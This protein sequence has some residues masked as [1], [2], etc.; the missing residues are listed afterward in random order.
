[1][2][3]YLKL[4]AACF[5][6][7]TAD[8]V[9]AQFKLKG[10]CIDKETKQ[11]VPFATVHVTQRSIW[12]DADQNGYF[13]IDV[14]PQDS[15]Y[16]SSVGYLPLTRTSASFQVP[17]T[18]FLQSVVISLPEI[19]IGQRKVASLG[20]LKAKKTFDMNSKTSSR[21]EMATRVNIPSG[22]KRFQLQKIN[23]AGFDF[24]ASNP[25]RIHV[26]SVGA[27]GQPDRELLT[28]DIVITSNQ[29]PKGV[30]AIDVSEQSIFLSANFFVA[31]QWI[32]DK[33][34]QNRINPSKRTIIGP[35]ILCTY[36]IK[37]TVTYQRDMSS[38]MGYKWALITDGVF[39]PYDYKIPEKLPGS[40]LNMLISCDILY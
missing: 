18:F 9:A 30:V 38:G 13:E 36:T 11:V 23:I 7:L 31:V 34:N 33:N 4:I 19:L 24:N 2:T 29:S 15:I 8:F 37:N 5:F 10:V 28:K 26:Y 16:I 21:F 1:M 3:K 25:V 6:L 32:S 22:I 20:Q 40:L 17:D 39:Y 12:T 27:L 14:Q 35:G